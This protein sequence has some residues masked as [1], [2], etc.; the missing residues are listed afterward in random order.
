MTDIQTI[1]PK[2]LYGINIDTMFYKIN[3]IMNELKRVREE[4]SSQIGLE[5]EMYAEHTTR[6]DI[7]EKLLYE[8]GDMTTNIRNS[9]GRIKND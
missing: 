2:Y 5:L 1:F 4:I 9:D 3:R 6:I 7:A 8:I